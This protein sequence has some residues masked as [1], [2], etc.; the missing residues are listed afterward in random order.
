MLMILLLSSH[1]T[2]RHL[3]RCSLQH[4]HREGYS[5]SLICLCTHH[6]Y[7]KN[8][9]GNVVMRLRATRST[10]RLLMR[11]MEGGKATNLFCTTPEATITR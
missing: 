8:C 4:M 10:C 2:R 1:S 11:Q 7:M 3:R 9:I 5:A 6:C